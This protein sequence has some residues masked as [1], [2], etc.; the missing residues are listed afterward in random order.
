MFEMSAVLASPST[1]NTESIKAE[2][3]PPVTTS[4]SNEY[5]E[6]C[7]RINQ[8]ASFKEPLDNLFQAEKLPALPNETNYLDSRG[9][10]L[11]ASNALRARLAACSPEER[12]EI[13]YKASINRLKDRCPGN[14]IVE[15]GKFA[16]VTCWEPRFAPPSPSGSDKNL[17]VSDGMVHGQSIAEIA[18]TRPVFGAFAE[19]TEKAKLEHLYPLLWRHAAT[20][21]TD[22][23][24]KPSCPHTRNV[25]GLNAAEGRQDAR[26]LYWKLCMTSRNPAV[27]P[28]VPGAV[29]AIIEPFA[30][31]WVHEDGMPVVW[32]EAGGPRARDVYSYF[33]FRCV[34]ESTVGENNEGKPITTW[35]M[36]YTKD[37]P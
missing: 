36:M 16:A 1:N 22:Y 23:L 15:A 21:P 20:A 2:A 5:L 32:L 24:S 6:R 8:K 3:T 11:P 9:R 18:T 7:A 12:E 14:F 25:L 33:G 26:L 35:Y 4:N 31:R 34:G 19:D 37:S 13:I 28:P 17:Q 30:K 29:R 10:A 27:Q